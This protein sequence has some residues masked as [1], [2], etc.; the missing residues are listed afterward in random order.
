M[1]PIDYAQL[2]NDFRVG[3][4]GASDSNFL[5][6]MIDEL[7]LFDGPLSADE[8]QSPFLSNVVPEP[9][10]LMLFAAMG[11]APLARRRRA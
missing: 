1:A 2:G 10:S 11:L 8:I 7:R 5:T 3:S 6:G 4:H 9:S